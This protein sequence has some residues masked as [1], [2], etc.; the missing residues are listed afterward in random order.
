MAIMMKKTELTEEEMN[1]VSGGAYYFSYY[2][3]ENGCGYEVEVIDDLTGEVLA[4]FENAFGMAE[5]FARERGL[6]DTILDWPA[7]K[8]IRDDYQKS[9]Q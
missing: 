9:L 2:C 1:R 4:C 7:L 8:K 5:D 6:S 3:D